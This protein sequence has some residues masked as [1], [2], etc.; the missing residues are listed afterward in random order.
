MRETDFLVRPL[1]E[2]M[3][4]GIV[5]RFWL[6]VKNLK[7]VPVILLRVSENLWRNE[8]SATSLTALALSMSQ[9][10]RVFGYS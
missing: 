1:E 10:Y 3:S 4:L 9:L 7:F 2:E 5:V 8:E 6:D